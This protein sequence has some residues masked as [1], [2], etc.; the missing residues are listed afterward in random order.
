MGNTR[1]KIAVFDTPA[2]DNELRF[3]DVVMNVDLKPQLLLD[4]VTKFKIRQSIISSVVNHAAFVEE[5][6]KRQT[7]FIEL[8]H[9]TPIPII[10]TYGTPA[11]LGRDR[12]AVVV[13]GNV[14][15]PKNDILVID[16]GTCITYDFIDKMSV[17]HGGSIAPG[18]QMKFKAVHTFT[19]QLPLIKTTELGSLTGKS[20]HEAIVSGVLHGTIAE[21]QG[22]IDKYC[23]EY[24][25]LRVLLTGGDAVFFETNLKS[26]IFACPNLVLQGINQILNYNVAKA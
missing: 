14:L 16:A 18:I 10:N 21:M 8:T 25:Q 22:I 20:T 6:L 12:L 4:W 2:N 1:T 9:H 15:H 5:I 23:Q 26:E 17:Y 24:P 7:F 11:T 13:A 3:Y 19:D